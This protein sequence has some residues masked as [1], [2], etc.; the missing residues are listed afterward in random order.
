MCALFFSAVQYRLF[1]ERNGYNNNLQL[2]LRAI[3]IKTI[4]SFDDESN[5]AKDCKELF[6]ILRDRVSKDH[7]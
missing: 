5:Q 7:L 4:I 1:K 6:P 2:A 3:G